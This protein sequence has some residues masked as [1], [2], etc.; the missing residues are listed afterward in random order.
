MAK[1][2]KGDKVIN[3]SSREKGIIVDVYPPRRGRQMYSVQYSD[4]INDELSGVL[5][6]DVDM[7]DPF[8]R[9]RQNYFNYYT[10][11]LKEN[12]AFKIRSSNNS[13]IS[14]LKASKTLFRPYQ[15]KPLLK[16]LE[17]D[18]RRVLIADEVGLGKTIEAGHIMLELKARNEFRNALVICP[19]SLINKWATE[20]T[21]KFGLAFIP[22]E[23]KKEL[24]H[25]L[26]NHNG[27]VRAVINYDK[28]RDESDVTQYIIEN[29]IKFSCIVCDESHKLRN[30]NTHV[31]AGAKQ[32]L[33]NA[34]SVVLMS[35]TPIM[36][37]EENLFNQLRL[38]DGEHYD[39][40]EV[41]ANNLQFNKPFVRALSRLNKG[42]SL[43]EIAE[44][45]ENAEVV[46]YNTINEVT[47]SSVTTIKSL[48]PKYRLLE[49]ILENLNSG[50]DTPAMRAKLQYDLA[51]MSPM[52]T[53]FS[54]T[55][56]K[57]VETRE[58]QTR[59][60]PH[61]HIV[62]L[63]ADESTEYQTQIEDYEEDHAIIDEYGNERK[64]GFGVV[65]LRR[66][67]AS[68]VWATAS[69]DTH[70]NAGRDVYSDKKDSKFDELLNIIGDVFSHG[71]NKLIVFGIFKKTLKY[72]KIRLERA[73]YR[74]AIM[75][76]GG[77]MDKNQVLQQFQFDDSIQILLTSEIGSEG[78]DM[79]FCNALVNYDL[80]WNPMVVEQRIGRIDRF[81]QKS[82][83]INIYNIVVSESILEDIY[84]RLLNRIG[85]F[86]ESIGDLEAILDAEIESN[87]TTETI[88]DAIKN[89]E[90]GFYSDKLTP[91][92]ALEKQKQIERA[93]EN[94]RLNLKKIE[95][96]LTNS[97]TNDAYFQNEIN[98]ILRN[99]SYVTERELQ[100]FL[101]LLLKEALT[102]C[103]LKQCE[104]ESCVY[105][106]SIPK[107]DTAVLR[108]FLE[109]HRPNDVEGQSLFRHF[110][111][112]TRDDLEIRITFDQ[113]RAFSDKRLEFINIYHPLII[114]GLL[115]FDKA[116]QETKNT[117]YFE[118]HRTGLP[119]SLANGKYILALYKISISRRV[120]GDKIQ[121]NESLYPL[122]FDIK[123]DCI[124][125]DRDLTEL[126]MGRAQVDGEYANM[127]E[128]F[129][130]DTDVV[131]NLRYDLKEQIYSYVEH[132]KEDTLLRIENAR[133]MRYQATLQYYESRERSMEAA[134][135]NQ[136]YMVEMFTMMNNDEERKKAERTLPLFR[137]N[138]RDLKQKKELDLDR[139]SRDPE[140]K[141]TEN[142][143]SINLVNLID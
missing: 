7:S 45:L 28:V 139:I 112:K 79:Q 23:D 105:V 141:V 50:E 21:E 32:I 2:N 91:E 13:T 95:E 143:H 22:I 68:S 66:Q 101:Q 72:L 24:I 118:L 9:I 25:E 81:G 76:G 20:L 38:L 43:P 114:A 83:K 77:K 69:D 47:T 90:R 120:F 122:L 59:R 115:Y 123:N 27:H 5:L 124:I 78:L 1:Y 109:N 102:T 131:E 134:I 37:D 73:G 82:E 62:H 103:A 54:R 117:F 96:G 116:R 41:F 129:K 64:G 132:Y 34:D 42:D 55:R 107:S 137:A 67:L 58:E 4:R 133:D 53:I 29:N 140:L 130:L 119:S 61:T 121:E 48:I 113:S 63:T 39:N 92:E 65:T 35:A 100:A 99:N 88:Q 128:G 75:Y 11:Y 125:E 6:P 93:I 52:N 40:Y 84:I 74:C 71:N 51:E 98:K 44:E 49:R 10:E 80:P 106:L 89:I 57:E 46:T 135:R 33:L 108:R 60:N 142:I 14:S 70:L 85:I 8:E 110:I 97:L 136:E 126:F 18:N 127:E 19:K 17:S 94:E 26:K 138:L 87:G 104:E 3:A 12:T 36:I 16:F 111:E 31:Y 15:F 86:R 56:K 30:S